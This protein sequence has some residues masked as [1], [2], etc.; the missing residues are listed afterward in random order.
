MGVYMGVYMYVRMCMGVRY[1]SITTH[2]TFR[3]NNTGETLTYV[4][5]FCSWDHVNVRNT[6]YNK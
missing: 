3:Y 5:L 4:S 1:Y 2:M 6:L